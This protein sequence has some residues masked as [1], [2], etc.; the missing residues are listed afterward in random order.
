MTDL[1]II[2]VGGTCLAAVEIFEA[3]AGKR[4]SGNDWRGVQ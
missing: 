1:F 3:V 2:L 4:S